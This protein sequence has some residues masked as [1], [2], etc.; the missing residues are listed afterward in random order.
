MEERELNPIEMLLDENNDDNIILYDEDGNPT[1]FEQ[2]AIIPNEAG[3]FVILSPVTKIEGVA[4]DEGMVFVI[5]ED[6]EGE[7][8]LTLV[9]D[10]EEIDAV[11]AEYDRLVEED[12]D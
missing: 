10:E 4:E 9:T 7:L 2:I 8:F 12:E 6:D 11:F 5:E 1:E 3:V